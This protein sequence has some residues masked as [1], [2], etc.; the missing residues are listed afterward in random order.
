MFNKFKKR[1]LHS[2]NGQFSLA[3]GT[4]TQSKN[5]LFDRN[6]NDVPQRHMNIIQKLPLMSQ[7]CYVSYLE[8][9]RV[10]S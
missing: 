9:R 5:L 8:E 2:Q 4:V 6:H 10:L 1:Q 3:E 7:H